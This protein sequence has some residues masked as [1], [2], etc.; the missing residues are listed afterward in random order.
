[1]LF[2]GRRWHDVAFAAGIACERL[3][4]ADLAGRQDE[5][6]GARLHHRAA[7]MATE[8]AGPI[9]ALRPDVVVGDVLTAA[10]GMVAELT[11][12]P[13]AELSPHPLYLPSRGLPPIGSGLAVGEGLRGR[14][15]DSL[16][17]RLSDRS[18]RQGR[19]HRSDARVSI[20]LPHID[21]GPGIRLIATLPALEVDR[22]DWPSSA[23]LVGPLSWDPN[24]AEL[25]P[26]PGD[27]P[28]VLVSP[29][30]ASGGRLGLLDA[31]VQG[32]RGVRMVGTV[33]GPSVG[34]HQDALHTDLPRWAVVG[35]G[36][37]EPLLRMANVVV[38][39][40]GHGLLAKALVAGKP[41][42][43]VPGGGDQRELAA[44]AERLG[45]ALVL[46][47]LTPDGLQAA[48]HEVL[49]NP[50]YAEAANRAAAS[51]AAVQSNP[52]DLC[53]ALAGRDP[54]RLQPIS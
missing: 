45:A 18:V 41:L 19:Q 29:S 21:P 54:G 36:R 31:A 16:L 22:P 26:P 32:L 52:V 4:I 38:S 35:P 46:R 3:P 23:Y 5:D 7:L 30:T 47:T 20:G 2:T 44:R 37:Q 53:R 43:L 15:R 13:W 11:G 14:A 24:G 34:A 17:R 1:M 33:L 8:L 28:L 9:A 39:G 51:L 12:T 49:T 50:S 27:A 40:A 6:A 48:V 10:G 42:V 25:D